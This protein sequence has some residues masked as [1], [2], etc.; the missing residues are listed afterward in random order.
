MSFFYLLIVT[1]HG[2]SF[3]QLVAGDG[4]VIR[5]HEAQKG[6]RPSDGQKVKGAVIGAQGAV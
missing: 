5:A 2:N 3:H 6:R 1:Y 4:P